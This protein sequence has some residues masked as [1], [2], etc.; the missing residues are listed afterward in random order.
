MSN[1]KKSSTVEPINQKGS[2]VPLTVLEARQA[3][4]MDTLIWILA[5]SM[6]LSLMCS[7]KSMILLLSRQTISLTITCG[8][9][10][11][12]SYSTE[13]ALNHETIMY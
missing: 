9:N 7:S 10:T 3:S 5:Q 12:F 1:N 11:N 6:E 4:V 2:R 8:M 13:L